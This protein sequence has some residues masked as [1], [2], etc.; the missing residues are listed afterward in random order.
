MR[1]RSDGCCR[2]EEVRSKVRP[3]T[4]T[5]AVYCIGHLKL[6]ARFNTR[7]CSQPQAGHATRHVTPGT[8]AVGS[9]GLHV[10]KDLYLEHSTHGFK[11]DASTLCLVCLERCHPG[12]ELRNAHSVRQARFTSSLGDARQHATSSSDIPQDDA[13]VEQST[14]RQFQRRCSCACKMHRTGHALMEISSENDYIECPS[15]QPRCGGS[16]LV[17]VCLC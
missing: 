13:V 10:R 3:F 1:D 11:F 7:S 16:K 6:W 5:L 8:R 17:C 4:H 2:C 9:S 15:L 12:S 14:R